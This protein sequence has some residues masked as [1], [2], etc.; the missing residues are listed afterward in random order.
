MNQDEYDA[1]ILRARRERDERNRA[2]ES[3]HFE[4]Q[5]DIATALYLVGN[6]QLALRHPENTGAA[7]AVARE[8]VAGLIEAMRKDG[9]RAH[10]E[11]ASLG[12]ANECED[13]AAAIVQ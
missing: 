3:A 10:A 1:L 12:C 2:G 5:F 6:L 4:L 13:E 8:T 11:L 9:F 7:A